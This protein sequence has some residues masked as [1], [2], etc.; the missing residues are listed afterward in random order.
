MMTRV[1]RRADSERHTLSGRSITLKM[2]P[3]DG[4][5]PLE[6]QAQKIRAS[7]LLGEGRLLR[8]FDFLREGTLAGRAP[9][10]L[11]LAHAVFERDAGFDVAQDALVRVYVHKLRR[12]LDDYYGRQ[13]KEEPV[14]L[15][16]PRGEY[17]LALEAVPGKA[18]GDTAVS[19]PSTTASRWRP[20]LLG[21]LAASLL[22]NAVLLA[23]AVPPRWHRA[24]P[25][26]PLKSSPIWSPI[27][28]DDRPIVILL[29]DYYL[30]GATDGTME[31][32]RLIR[33][34]SINS[35]EELSEYLERNPRK[36][37]DYQ[38]ISLSYLPTSTA[39]VLRDVIPILASA[40]KPLKIALVSELAPEQ[41]KNADIV[42]VGLVSGL[43]MLRDVVFAGSRLTVGD[44]YDELID[45]RSGT[46]YYSGEE[47]RFLGKEKYHDFGYL[48]SFP[49]PQGNHFLIISG[50][51][52]TGLACT[53]ETLTNTAGVK[54]LRASTPPEASG[55]EALYEV[56]GLGGASVGARLV[57]A[58]PLEVGR[59]WR[60]SVR[61]P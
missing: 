43:G 54:Q 11:E 59:L 24:D 4:S 1:L 16:I 57:L 52:D 9:K 55:V 46:H 2:Q 25:L 49:G 23:L 34:F 22:I 28:N 39:Q 48:A 37:G 20:W 3:V 51:R 29:G 61:A 53:G 15:V 41:L 50:M 60:E 6:E 47:M 35:R 5:T 21:G 36:I 38:D 45:A 7:G 19:G 32:Q 26:E 17:R 10:E 30:F 27:L 33:E 13:G 8:L 40:H 18:P 58:G 44:T 14:R 42:Y 56:Y 31:V 12:K